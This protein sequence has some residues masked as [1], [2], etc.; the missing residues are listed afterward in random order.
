MC[1][2]NSKKLVYDLRWFENHFDPDE[3]ELISELQTIHDI[4][5]VNFWAE[6]L[7]NLQNKY[8]SNFR[9]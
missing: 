8:D 4:R 2:R 3:L 6:E 9:Q 5:D 1:S 7:E